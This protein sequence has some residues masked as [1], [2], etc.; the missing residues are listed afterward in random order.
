MRALSAATLLLA[1]ACSGGGSGS[2]EPSLS[3][4]EQA[5]AVARAI[6]ADP[7]QADAALAEQGMTREAFEALLYEIAA[8]PD[9]TAAYRDALQAK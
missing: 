1:L 5:A 4:V 9:K 7:A 6:Q 3:P 2:S 8:D